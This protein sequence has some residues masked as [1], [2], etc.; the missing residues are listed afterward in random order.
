MRKICIMELLSDKSVL[1]FHKI[2]QDEVLHLVEVIRQLAG[3]SVN[4]TEQLFSHTSSMV[5]R[6]AFGQVSKED[7]YKFVR[8]MKQVLALEEGFHMADL[9][10]SY[11][12]FHVLT[13]LKPELLKIHH[14]MDI[15]FENLIKEHINNHTRNKKFIADPNQKDLI[16][17]L[18]QIRDSGDLQFPI[19]NDDIKAIIFVVD[20]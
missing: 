20:P 9:F 2:R 14:K 7:R 5:C 16:D 11:R 1:S 10:L 3:K 6:A 4:I 15:I 19:S 18:L 8:L 12:I 13:G 17:V